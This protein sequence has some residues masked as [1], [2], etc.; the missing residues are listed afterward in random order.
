MSKEGNTHLQ[1]NLRTGAVFYIL[2]RSRSIR[3]VS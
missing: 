3:A 2:A 1:A